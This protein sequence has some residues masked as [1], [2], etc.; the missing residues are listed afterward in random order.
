MKLYHYTKYNTLVKYILP[1]MKLKLS[2]LFKTNDPTEGRPTFVYVEADPNHHN[3]EQDS[4]TP[5][6]MY[7]NE[8]KKY[9]FVKFTRSA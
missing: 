1:T 6:T 7:F 9:K 3:I 8:Y 4:L 5:K 2:S